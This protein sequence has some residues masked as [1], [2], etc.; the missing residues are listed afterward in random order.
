MARLSCARRTLEVEAKQATNTV[1]R[2]V[3]RPDSPNDTNVTKIHY[4]YRATRM[5]YSPH[6]SENYI[7]SPEYSEVER[8]H[9]PLT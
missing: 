7:Y 5:H 4:K 8:F 1:K 9:M 6:Y 3:R 2:G